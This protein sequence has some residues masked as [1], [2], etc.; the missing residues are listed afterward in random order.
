MSTRRLADKTIEV[1][2]AFAPMVELLEDELHA[3][4][5]ATP[6]YT[7]D[8]SGQAF[9]IWYL[10]VIELL[11]SHIAAGDDHQPMTRIEVELM[12]RC[13][14]TAATLAEA[15]RLLQ[16]FAAMIY[17]R[18]GAHKLVVQ[19]E[20]ARF[21][22]DS[23]RDQRSMA[24]SLGDI[25]G[26]FAFKQLFQW[27][28]G[29][30]AQVELVGVGAVQRADVM[31]FLR[32]F[33]APVLA[34]G[35]TVYLQYSASVMD[36]PIVATAGDF[37]TFFALFP[38]ALSDDTAEL[39]QQVAALI[40]A[41]INQAMPIPGQAAV[42]RSLGIPLSTF[43]R[44]LASQDSSFRQI[45]EQCLKESSKGMLLE[46]LAVNQI[47]QRLGFSDSESFRRAFRRWTDMSPSQWRSQN[48]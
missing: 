31:P 5:I 37:E 7:A 48:S 15:I 24:G 43:R 38:C 39:G 1:A 11:E 28:T 20:V 13:A 46:Q 6:A 25:S 19:D 10:Q 21:V 23:Q 35:E 9:S 3:A 32:L 8:S 4:G 16:E 45:R 30:R 17:P 33:G 44:H 12:C 34:E 36:A 27:L 41:A 42:A 47:A 2:S 40:N 22:F 26:L 14:L 29:G 18:G